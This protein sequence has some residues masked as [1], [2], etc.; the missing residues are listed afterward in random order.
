MS[1][2]LKYLENKAKILKSLTAFGRQGRS[3]ATGKIWKHHWLKELNTAQEY[4]K[5]SKSIC[6]FMVTSDYFWSRERIMS[7]ISGI[8]I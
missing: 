3:K 4:L 5:V 8:Y 1:F 6:P 7:L 2:E